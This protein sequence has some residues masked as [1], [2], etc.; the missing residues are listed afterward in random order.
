[1]RDGR[2]VQIRCRTMSY[3]TEN[4]GRSGLL[5][6]VGD[7]YDVIQLFE[8]QDLGNGFNPQL[9]TTLSFCLLP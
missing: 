6:F 5:S 9:G 1:M 2:K 7:D 3:T 4:R 8:G